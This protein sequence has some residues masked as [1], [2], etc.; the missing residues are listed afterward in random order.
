MDKSEIKELLT[1]SVELI[2]FLSEK[3]YQLSNIGLT[4]AIAHRWTKAG[5]YLEEPKSKGRRKYNAIEYVWLRLVS[6]LRGFGLPIK[7][8][9]KLKIFITNSIDIKD[10]ILNLIVTQAEL[11]SDINETRKLKEELKNGFNSYHD[12][13]KVTNIFEGAMINSVLTMLIYMTIVE[14]VDAHL[15]ITKDG[16]CFIYNEQ[17]F[18][19][20]LTSDILNGPYICFPLRHI[21]SDFI[22][23]EELY[24]F[25]LLENDQ[26]LSKP[27]KVVLKLLRQHEISSLT[28]RVNEGKISLIE[29]EEQV[30]VS[31][32]SGKLFDLI[33]QNSYQEIQYK[34]EQGKIVSLKRK[35]KYKQ[36]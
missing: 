33:R 27:E 9:I 30:D 29:T 10:V 23:R 1:E 24:D 17:P 25:A 13:E 6:E 16:T 3:K 20:E 4:D 32:V 11:D 26:E 7:S 2:E 15:L 18:T 19:D 22:D 14:K 36:N 8:I 31:K 34:T 35:T 5:V 28:V 21:V 12:F